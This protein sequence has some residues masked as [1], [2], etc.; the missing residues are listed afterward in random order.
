LKK[1]S[2]I[3]FSKVTDMTDAF[4]GCSALEEI[5]ELD[6]RNF[7][8]TDSFFEADNNIHTIGKLVWNSNIRLD[9]F[10]VAMKNL[11]KLQNCNF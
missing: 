1:I 4:D 2:N 9:N 7:E 6:L 8:G 3:D 11:N 5:T 10:I